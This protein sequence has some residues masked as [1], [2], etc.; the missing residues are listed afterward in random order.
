[1]EFD[2][3]LLLMWLDILEDIVGKPHLMSKISYCGWEISVI[4]TANKLTKNMNGMVMINPAT[5]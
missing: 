5:T 1:M 3:R 2:D 4:T